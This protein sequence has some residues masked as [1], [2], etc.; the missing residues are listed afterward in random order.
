MCVWVYVLVMFKIQELKI[1]SLVGLL[2]LLGLCSSSWKE[3]IFCK[4][5]F[6]IYSMNFSWWSFLVMCWRIYDSL[7]RR[8]F[9]SLSCNWFMKMFWW[10]LGDFYVVKYWLVFMCVSVRSLSSIKCIYMCRI[11][12][13][14]NKS[15]FLKNETITND[16]FIIYMHKGLLVI[17]LKI[18]I[19]L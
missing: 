5:W 4:L 16:I 17:K 11:L 12:I 2:P 7:L 9:R 8:D 18:M 14:N 10:I 13:K 6:W 19:N 1:W 3:I 15:F